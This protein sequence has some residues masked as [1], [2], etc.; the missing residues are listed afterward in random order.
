M[1]KLKTMLFNIAKRIIIKRISN[2][3]TKLTPQ[4]LIDRGW[5]QYCDYFIE[6]NIKDR[7]RISIQFEC[8]GYRVWHSEKM[9]FIASERSVEWF[10]LYYLLAHPDNRII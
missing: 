8:Y 2:S 5:V 4:Y 1:E 9:I 3:K 10:E 7:D 6:P